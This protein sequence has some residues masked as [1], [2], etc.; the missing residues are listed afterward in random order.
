MI[1]RESG[2]PELTLVELIG[3]MAVLGAS[4]VLLISALDVTYGEGV[5]VKFG[6]PYIFLLIE[7]IYLAIAFACGILAG[8]PARKLVPGLLWSMTVF[9][10]AGVFVAFPLLIRIAGSF[11]LPVLL[12]LAQVQSMHRRTGMTKAWAAYITLMSMILGLPI[13]LAVASNLLT[14]K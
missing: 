2:P 4:Q 10:V 6:P 7:F 3:Y 5:A 13:A 12:L 9:R 1:K 14:N 11:S 8:E